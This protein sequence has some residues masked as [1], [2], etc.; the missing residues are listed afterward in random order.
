MSPSP[1][2]SAAVVCSIMTAT[3]GVGI[4]TPVTATAATSATSPSSTARPAE[5]VNPDLDDIP[6]NQSLQA[7]TFLSDSST[8]HGARSFVGNAGQD[9]VWLLEGNTVRDHSPA[10]SGVF[11]LIVQDRHE[12]ADLEVIRVHTAA[13]GTQ[14]RTARIPMPRTI[15]IPGLRA[16]NEFTPGPRTFSGTATAGATVV[17]TDAKT[18]RTLFSTVASSPRNGVGS[19]S[20]ETELAAGTEYSIVFK[21]TTLDDRTNSLVGADFS[22][23][24]ADRPAAPTL[25]TTERRLDGRFVLTGARVDAPESVVI[26]KESGEPIATATL[27]EA[28]WFADVPQELI[29]TTV[30]AVTRS[31]EG[32]ASAR[33]PVPL[34]QL[35]TDATVS[36]PSLRSVYVHPSGDVQV[37]GDADD[38]PALWVLDG[39][40]VVGGVGHNE[41]WS[42]VID[43]EQTG[44]QLDIVNLGFDGQG[45]SSMSERVALPRLLKID[46]VSETN[47][48]TPGEREFSGSAEAGATVT[49]TDA[50]GKELFS[51]KVSGTRSGVGTW[52][53]TADLSSEDG[54]EVTFTQ[55]TADGRKSIMRDIAF[56]ADEDDA[57]A[58]IVVTTPAMNGTAEGPRPTFTG[59]GQAGATIEIR[60]TSR[61]VTTAE[62][63][64]DGTWSAVSN[65]DLG[66]GSYALTA[67]QTTRDNATSNVPIRF[68]VN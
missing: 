42:Y 35:A 20:A 12:D 27:A 36:K 68:T 1:F 17:A 23:A 2:R 30:Y 67:K 22:P 57:V 21:Q 45:F 52:K 48:Y 58:P 7:P 15:Q 66:R 19:W 33:T 46:G 41:M 6:I 53:T 11:R 3:L 25:E 51:T 31:A 44:Q 38:A 9:A 50:T 59:T 34:E 40:R 64:A 37:V 60:G 63:Q 13:D 62:V 24:D 65:I 39:D 8:L 18:G 49:A 55:T 4:L 56:D 43:S 54:Y 5:S 10:N 16:Q 29:G 32:V 28:G 47:T 26:E 61:V 14:T